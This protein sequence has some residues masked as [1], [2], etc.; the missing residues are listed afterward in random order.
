MSVL[1]DPF[2]LHR[3]AMIRAAKEKERIMKVTEKSLGER[4]HLD[5]LI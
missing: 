5:N 2:E 1:N 3:K 4:I